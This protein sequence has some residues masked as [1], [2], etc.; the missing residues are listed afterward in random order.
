MH[1]QAHQL[2]KQDKDVIVQH[3]SVIFIFIQAGN[4]F[5]LWLHSYWF[6]QLNLQTG[7]LTDKPK[8]KPEGEHN[9]EKQEIG[10]A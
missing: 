8:A 5:W 1:G 6:I 4:C 9:V 2:N 7:N 10:R 3:T